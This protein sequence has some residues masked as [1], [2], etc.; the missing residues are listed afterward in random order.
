MGPLRD[1]IYALLS[2]DP[3]ERPES[4]V[5][6]D[7]LAVAL[8]GPV[9]SRIRKPLV[10]RIRRPATSKRTKTASQTLPDDEIDALAKAVFSCRC[11]AAQP[12][13]LSHRD[14]TL[15]S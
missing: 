3:A 11:D 14:G 13:Y 10:S 9:T 12:R 7:E 5:V 8:Q 6:L 4:G 2:K 15:C 1:L